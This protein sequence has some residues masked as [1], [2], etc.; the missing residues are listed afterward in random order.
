MKRSKE[1]QLWIGNISLLCHIVGIKRSIGKRG[2]WRPNRW[3][4]RVRKYSLSWNWKDSKRFKKRIKHANLWLWISLIS[5][6]LTTTFIKSLK[7]EEWK[8]MWARKQ[9]MTINWKWSL[10]LSLVS[11][12][13]EC[14]LWSSRWGSFI[15]PE[16][17]HLHDAET[18][19]NL[20]ERKK[21]S[22]EIFWVS[23]A[24]AVTIIV[25]ICFVLV[26]LRLNWGGKTVIT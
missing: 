7:R 9:N 2:K 22:E 8:F 6:S 20:K 1:G 15:E 16:E 5:Q 23:S 26:M 13:W 18:T 21:L 14:Y 24:T 19:R 11:E 17:D 12:S 4:I 3:S 25:W 10:T